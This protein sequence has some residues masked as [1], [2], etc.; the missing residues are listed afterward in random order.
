MNPNKVAMHD[1]V[2]RLLET[3]YAL[4]KVTEQLC[5]DLDIRSAEL[6]VE[7]FMGAVDRG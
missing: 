7:L 3:A 4:K 2:G 5:W 6:S 1:A